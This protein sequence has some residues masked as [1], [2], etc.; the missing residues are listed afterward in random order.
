MADQHHSERELHDLFQIL[1]EH[2]VD[3][4]EGFG[5]TIHGRISTLDNQEI[6]EP[7]TARAVSVSLLVNLG[8]LFS[9][10]FG[11]DE[12]GDDEP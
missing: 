6:E 11:I 5:E 8:N 2:V 12:G 3:V 4:V 7:P 10:L 1:R 9:G